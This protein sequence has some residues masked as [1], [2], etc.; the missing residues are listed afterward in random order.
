MATRFEELVN[1]MIN[2]S[3]GAAATAA[4]KGKEVMDGLSAKGEEVRGN[5]G[6]PDFARSMADVFERAGGAFSDVTERVSASGAT[7]ADKV[8]DELILARLR[9][10]SRVE[11]EAFIAHVKD[12]VESLDSS[13][14]QVPVEHVEQA[15]EQAEQAE[16]PAPSE[17]PH[18]E[19]ATASADDASDACPVGS[20]AP[21]SSASDDDDPF[22][23]G[24]SA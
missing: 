6:A 1:G 19:G 13:A 24:A 23:E 20:A 4:E 11:R 2:I 16:E 14:V 9:P 17:A 7:T 21:Q 5:A 22:D 10:V 18:T 12:L 15:A 8:L 3:V